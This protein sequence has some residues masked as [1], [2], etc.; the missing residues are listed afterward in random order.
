MTT[1]DQL[2]L[3]SQQGTL[4]VLDLHPYRPVSKAT[5]AF[6]TSDSG[7]NEGRVKSISHAE[8]DLDLPGRILHLRTHA[9]LPPGNPGSCRRRS[10]HHL[11]EVLG[12]PI[13]FEYPDLGRGS[14]A[15]V[16]DYLL[17]SVLYAGWSVTLLYGTAVM[18]LISAGSLT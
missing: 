2:A 12:Q 11:G 13:G 3:S 14:L 18:G 1:S 17:Q 8:F 4:F 5:G 7:R 10:L 15:S 16:S 6:E 9:Q